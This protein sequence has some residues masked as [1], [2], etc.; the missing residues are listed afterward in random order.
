TFLLLFIILFMGVVDMELYSYWGFKLD[1]T[2]LIY[3]KTPG[4]ALASINP[5]EIILLVALFFFLFFLFTRVY[6]KFFNSLL[7]NSYIR[8]YFIV[9]SGL[10]SLL[11][12]FILAR[13][14]I[15]I[16]AM[17]LSHVYF[18]QERFANHSA[19]NVTW[20][21][22]YSFLERKK[23]QTSQQFMDAKIANDLVYDT[24]S[25]ESELSANIIKP[26]SNILLIILESYS[27]KIISAFG[28][29]DSITPNL[30]KLAGKSVVFNNFYASGDRSDKG[31]VS[32]FSGYPAQPTTSIIDYPSKSQKLPFIYKPFSENG[33]ETAFY[34]GGDLNF[35]N[36]KSYFSNPYVD[37]LVTKDNFSSKDHKQKWGVPD[38][39]LFDR[40]KSDIDKAGEPFFYSCFTLS[41]HEP[42]DVPMKPVF[43]TKNRDQLSKNGFYYTDSVLN[44]FLSEAEKSAWWD[45][46]LIIITADHGSRSPGNT[47][48]HSREKFHI[49]MLWTGGAL[50]LNDSTI[51]TA[52]SQTDMPATLLSLF[53]FDYS[54]FDFS[55]N[56][57]NKDLSDFAYYAFNNGFGCIT[58]SGYVIYDI[59]FN[60]CLIDGVEDS[61]KSL[62]TGKALLQLISSDFLKK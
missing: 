27:N 16:S 13:G 28:G 44:V 1:I 42:F 36:F 50:L 4:D 29:E 55:R 3:I 58:P 9:P 20:N 61:H 54:M 39:I 41:S 60:K 30:N 45:R 46:T 7:N 51:H 53:G 49:P 8:W 22:L 18:H 10:L 40:L 31:L 6:R 2:P 21:T 52:G 38:G 5:T 32:I 14:G 47:Q 48:N 56:L 23:L 37:R 19:I 59:D 34:Y 17:N 12:L 15:G 24:F 43:G 35:A 57:L 62:E 25:Y 26:G 11:I 33:Y